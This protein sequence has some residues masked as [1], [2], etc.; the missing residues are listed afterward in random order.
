M[1]YIYKWTHDMRQECLM[2]HRRS[3]QTSSGSWRFVSSPQLWILQRAVK[4]VFLRGVICESN[5]GR[6]VER[7]HSRSFAKLLGLRGPVLVPATT[8]P[9]LDLSLG[10][11]AQPHQTD[12]FTLKNNNTGEES[13]ST[14][15]CPRQHP[16]AGVL[17]Y[18]ALPCVW[19]I[20]IC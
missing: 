16:Q 8:E 1:F 19:Y 13:V 7:R 17:S 11:A 12:D 14:R 3:L 9:R 20:N 2:C 10:F 4:H 15:S 18:E 6:V 5:N